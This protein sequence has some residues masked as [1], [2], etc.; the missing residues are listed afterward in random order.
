METREIKTMKGQALRNVLVAA[1]GIAI[2]IGGSVGGQVPTG[3][4][5]VWSTDTLATIQA[6]VDA[7]G[8]VYFHPGTYSWTGILYVH[9]SVE[10]TGPKPVGDFDTETGLDARVWEVRLRKSPVQIW[11]PVPDPVI[12]VNCP[13]DAQ[14]VAINNLD[15]ECSGLGTCILL[16][17]GGDSITIARCRAKTENDGYGI[18]SWEA[19]RVSVVVEDCHIEAGTEGFL[20]PDGTPPNTDG[21]IFG[22]SNHA[23]VKV[24]HNIVI[25]RCDTLNVSNAVAFEWH[26]NPN[27]EITISRNWLQSAGEG[28]TVFYYDSACSVGAFCHNVVIGNYH[29]GHY[30]NRGRGGTI[31]ANQFEC[32]GDGTVSFYFA[33][34]ADLTVRGNV[35]R[36]GVLTGGIILEGRCS[37]NLFVAN[38]LSGLRAGTGQIFVQPE[39]HGNLFTKNVI[40]TLASGGLAAICC[41][42]DHNDFIRNDYG[43][44]EIPGLTTS[45]QPC[46]ILDVTSE[47]NLVFESAG[48][49]AGT[50]GATEQVLE[51][52]REPGCGEPPCATANVVVG[53]SADVLAEDINPG[54]AQRVR[55]TLSRLELPTP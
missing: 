25:N 14:N 38:D 55:D 44:S 16:G 48:F 35:F 31:E 27:A 23:T 18:V 42:G 11:E 4:T 20:Y 17:G 45:D 34:S 49:P 41:S 51:L 47:D 7:G 36:G 13:G 33:N 43:S 32:Q 5:E 1:A 40:G 12:S 46:L 39:C 22:R 3:A 28:L 19:G 2:I 50:G 15:I 21:I 37:G 26:Q 29:F 24:E 52:C 8:V 30:L 54:V 9:D 6:A 53:H 10:L